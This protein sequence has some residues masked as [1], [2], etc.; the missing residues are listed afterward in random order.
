[1]N[2]PEKRAAP[3][4]TAPRKPR[5]SRQHGWS[6]VELSLTLA[7]MGVLSAALFHTQGILEQYRHQRFV[8]HVQTLLAEM[9]AY[10]TQHGRWPGDCNSDGLID[11][12]FSGNE[13]AD[14]LDYAATA[15]FAPASSSSAAYQT[16]TVCPSAT[17]NPYAQVNVTFNELKRSGLHAMGQPNRSMG[18]HGLSGSSFA[19]SFNTNSSTAETSEDRFNALLLTNVPIVAGRKLATAIDGFDGDAANA[20]SVRRTSDLESFDERWTGAGET[21]RKRIFVVVFFDRVP[22]RP[23]ASP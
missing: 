16:G 8:H 4:A 17:L 18:D 1:M 14:D 3:S 9:R 20:F 11:Y 10:R 19:G 2:A 12:T 15:D 13:V 6:L 5:S 21:D 22:P 7:V 23:L